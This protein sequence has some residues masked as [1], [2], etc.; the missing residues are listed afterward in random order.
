MTIRLC[1]VLAI[2]FFSKG[3]GATGAHY[4]E[5]PLQTSTKMSDD[6]KQLFYDYT[7]HAASRASEAFRSINPVI[8]VIDQ[9]VV[10]DAVAAGSTEVLKADLESLGLR[11]SIAF[12]RIV[13]GELPIT[14][15]PAMAELPS[16]NFARAATALPQKGSR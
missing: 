16:L 7:D 5:D 2:L 14:A 15:I 9:R 11:Q 6:L 12:G 1:L 3:C 13:S 4:A 8:R 10:I